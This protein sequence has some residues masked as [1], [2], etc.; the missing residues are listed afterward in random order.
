[1]N[2]LW[3]VITYQLVDC[4]SATRSSKN[5]N[6]FIIGCI[7]SFF[8]NCSGLFPQLASSAGWNTGG[9][10]GVPIKGQDFFGYDLLNIAKRFPRCY[11]VTVDN[12]ALSIRSFKNA[13]SSHNILVYGVCKLNWLNII[14]KS[15]WILVLQLIILNVF[16]IAYPINN[17]IILSKRMLYS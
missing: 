1:M 7:E 10:V 5:E 13:V 16:W 8:Q 15:F 17:P 14:S 9:S 2:T 12:L 6:I 3:N 4:S 11:V